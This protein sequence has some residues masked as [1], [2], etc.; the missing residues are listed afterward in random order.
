MDTRSEQHGQVEVGIVSHEGR[1]FAALG[2]V[3]DGDRIT[4]YLG[5]D[6]YL[7]KWDGTVIGIYHITSSWRTPKSFVSGTMNQVYAKMDGQWYVG[8]SAGEGMLFRGRKVRH[9]Q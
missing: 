5:K 2:S 6:G 1:E 7:T 3:I 9:G 4:A 8:R